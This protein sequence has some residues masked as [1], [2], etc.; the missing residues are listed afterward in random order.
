MKLKKSCL[1]MAP[2]I[3]LG[4]QAALAQGPQLEEVLVTATKRVTAESETP[5][6]MDAVTGAQL[7][8]GNIVNLADLAESLPSVIIGEGLTAGSINIRGLGSGQERGLEQSVAMFIDDV[9]MPRSRMYRAPFFDAERVEV[10]RGPQAVL[11]GLNATAGTIQIYSAT[12]Q[13]GDEAHLSLTGAYEA[14]YDGYRG[15]LVAGGSLGDSV[16]GR[17]AVRYSET[18]DWMDNEFTGEEHGNR[19]ETVVRGSLVWD[20]TEDLRLTAKLSYADSE[21]HIYMGE[22]YGD[23][24]DLVT[25]VLLGALGGVP[26][27]ITDDAELNWQNNAD[28]V[29]VLHWGGEPGFDTDVTNF[30]LKADYVVGEGDLTAIYAYSDFYFQQIVTTGAIGANVFGNYLDEDHSQHSLELRYTSADD[31][32][33]S[34]IAGLYAADSELDNDIRTHIGGDFLGNFVSDALAPFDNV[35]GPALTTLDTLTVSPYFSGTFNI[36][37]AFRLVAGVRYSYTEKDYVRDNVEEDCLL[38][39]TGTLTPVAPGISCGSPDYEDDESWENWMPEIIAQWDFSD[40]GMLYAKA[41]ESA[42]SGTFQVSSV[43]PGRSP[44]IDDETAQS[45]ELGM[46]TRFMD[47]RL[48]LNASVFHTQYEDLQLNSFVP[49]EGDTPTAT[50]QNAGEMTSQGVEVELNFAA[51]DWLLLGANLGYLDAEYD[52]FK[53]GPC[54]PGDAPNPDPSG[55][56]CV[57][58]GQ[59]PPFAPETS[60]SVYADLDIPL[61]GN[62]YLTGGVTMSFSDDY[63]TSGNLDPVYD[64]S[65]YEMW[66]ARIGLRADD[67]KWN[68]AVVGKNLSDE[69]VLTLTETAFDYG[70]GYLGMPKTVTLQA[71]YN[72]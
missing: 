65:S 28:P 15:E 54:A 24:Y 34:Y 69:E 17:I 35:T 31:R 9:Y 4:G 7:Q 48:E 37:D 46:K 23:T 59:T 52:D 12:T 55:G 13:P 42:K 26:G 62:L 32:F 18:G 45:L 3:L 39:L 22:G 5:L 1:M 16:G 30:S 56:G 63:H 70:I 66:D 6:A 21:Q 72:F 40:A 25:N 71:T 53:S 43:I 20:A 2:A 51:T 29:Q 41:S 49:V 27:A 47:S 68:V 33:F 36:T 58:D 64:Q 57:K 44:V 11:F 60:G 50:T 38:Y 8:A 10:M 61:S 19:E 14:E 67:D